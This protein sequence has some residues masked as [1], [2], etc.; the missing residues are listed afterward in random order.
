MEVT[1]ESIWHSYDGVTYV[2]K[3]INLL[4]RNPDIYLLVGP[5]GSGK[6][7]LLKIASLIIKPSRG[8]VAVDG[9]SFWDLENS[10]REL[11]RG[12]IAYVHDKPILVR[13]SVRYNIELGLR[14]RKR[15]DE[16]LVRYYVNRYGLREVE[17]RNVNK[18]SAGQAKIVS[19]IRALVLRPKILVLDEPFT[20]LDT[21][22]TKLL[23]EDI[24]RITEEEKSLVLIASHYMYKD[25]KNMANQLIEMINGEIQNII[26][27]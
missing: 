22:R 10:S 9:K 4:F 12:S 6:T 21:A 18:L 15:V 5:N 7:T 26:S 11:I 2:L 27:S 25:L 24:S 1:L 20:Y 17:N 23:I 13:G 19:I 8:R 14:L 3:N 16:S